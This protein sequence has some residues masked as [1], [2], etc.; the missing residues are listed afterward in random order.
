MS[1]SEQAVAARF[2]Q[3]EKIDLAECLEIEASPE[4]YEH[5]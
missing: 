5:K 2:P 1:L 3:I 4:W